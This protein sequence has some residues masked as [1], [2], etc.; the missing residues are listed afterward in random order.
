M[1]IHSNHISDLEWTMTGSMIQGRNYH[2][3]TVLDDGKVLVV[4][5]TGEPRD[6]NIN[7]AELFDPVTETWSPTGSINIARRYHTATLL[8]NGQ[9]LVTGGGDETT[10]I[11][12]A[13]LYDP[14]TGQWT[15]TGDMIDSRSGHAATLLSNGKVLITGGWTI[16]NEFLNTAELYDI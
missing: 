1:D 2:T 5:G 4:G 14:L 11:N 13:E 16:G 10:V 12:T 3:A 9:V 8:S 7:S 15:R 6:N